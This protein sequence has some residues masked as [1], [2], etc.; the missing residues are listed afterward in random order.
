M[1]SFLFRCRQQR[2]K[3]MQRPL[4]DDAANHVVKNCG[5]GAQRKVG[6]RVNRIAQIPEQGPFQRCLER[7]FEDKAVNL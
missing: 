6:E 5:A 7:L 1:P 3:N 4:R 2:F